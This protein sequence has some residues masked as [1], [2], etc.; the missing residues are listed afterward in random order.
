MSP[1][2]GPSWG[3][4]KLQ[5]SSS[6][7]ASAGDKQKRIIKEERVPGHTPPVHHHRSFPPAL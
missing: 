1:L 4:G 3:R 6:G 2:P 5:M 7:F